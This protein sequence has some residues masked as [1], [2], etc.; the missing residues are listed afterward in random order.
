MQQSLTERPLKEMNRFKKKIKKK[1]LKKIAFRET[2]LMS[3]DARYASR[4][5]MSLSVSHFIVAFF[6]LRCRLS[7]LGYR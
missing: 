5:L 1:D 6:S 3:H 2:M 7:R 4:Q